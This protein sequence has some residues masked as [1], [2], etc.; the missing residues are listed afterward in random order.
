MDS[1]E[2]GYKKDSFFFCWSMCTP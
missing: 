1:V 2:H